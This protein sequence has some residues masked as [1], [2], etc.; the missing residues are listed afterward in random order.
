M[1]KGDKKGNL[2]GGNIRNITGAYQENRNEEKKTK[3]N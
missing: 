1:I 2:N 3:K